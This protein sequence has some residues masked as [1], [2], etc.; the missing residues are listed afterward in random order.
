MFFGKQAWGF[1][2]LIPAEKVTSLL[3]KNRNHLAAFQVTRNTVHRIPLQVDEVEAGVALVLRN[4]T[5]TLP[6]RK[7]VSHP[8]SKDPF[9]GRFTSYHRLLLDDDNFAACDTGCETYAKAQ[10][11]QVC[12]TAKDS[13]TNLNLVRLN[14]R[15][16]K[17][18]AFVVDCGQEPPAEERVTQK[19]KID[20]DFKG[21]IFSTDLFRYEY[22]SDRS[23]LPKS[24]TIHPDIPL[25]SDSEL[26]VYLKPKMMFNM[27]FTEK[28]IF[29]E[30][31][32]YTQSNVSTA[33]EVS[34]A[35][36]IFG[37]KVSP[38][39]CCDVSVYKDALYLPVM[40]DLPFAGSSFQE[41]SGLFFGFTYPGDVQKDV[42]IFMP[43]LL[44]LGQKP[45]PGSINVVLIKAKEKRLAIGF[46][47]NNKNLVPAVA[48]PDDLK[49]N[50]FKVVKSDLG[51]F[52]DITKLEKGFQH[53]DMWFFVGDASQEK[54]LIEYAKNGIIFEVKSL[55]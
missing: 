28:D 21:R 46:R 36:D 4:P 48:F 50:M 51:V 35:I 26:S 55:N 37:M 54:T 23:I 43:R 32:S 33:I 6:L 15:H 45:T 3:G 47:T 1:P 49:R 53:F 10:L 25:L 17:T 40:I 18:S 42:E 38:H 24:V 8:D 9:A 12:S 7:K 39:V 22:K 16:L 11:H 29:S 13:L 41:G 14:L 44:P 34:F 27:Y 52:Y 19:Q 2:V 20:A 30:F 5:H 31:T